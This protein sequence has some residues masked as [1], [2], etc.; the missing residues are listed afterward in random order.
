MAARQKYQRWHQPAGGV[1][2]QLGIKASAMKIGIVKSA[3]PSV[4]CQTWRHR[5]E[6][7]ASAHI[8]KP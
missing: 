3:L 1:S 6:G 8:T 2:K 7:E 4:V 5:G